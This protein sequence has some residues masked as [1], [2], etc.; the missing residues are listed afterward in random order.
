MSKCF[1]SQL[2]ECHK[3]V[4]SSFHIYLPRVNSHL[5]KWLECISA[6]KHFKLGEGPRWGLLRDCK[7][8]H[9]LQKL[10]FE[11]LASVVAGAACRAWSTRRISHW[12]R[13]AP[14]CTRSWSSCSTGSSAPAPSA[15]PRRGRRLRVQ[16]DHGNIIFRYGVIL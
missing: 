7:T 9:N 5:A 15:S 12:R 16:G 14:P 10:S 1:S 4:Y 11:A 6:S 2:S 3:C 8:W 13:A